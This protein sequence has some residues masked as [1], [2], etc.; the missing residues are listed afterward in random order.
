MKMMII[1][2]RISNALCRL[3]LVSSAAC[4]HIG[5]RSPW[6]YNRKTLCS[7]SDTV[8]EHRV[9][10]H[11]VQHHNKFSYALEHDVRNTDDLIWLKMRN[12]IVRCEVVKDTHE[13]FL[14]SEVVKDTHEHFKEG[15]SKGYPWAFLLSFARQSARAVMRDMALSFLWAYCVAT[16]VEHRPNRIRS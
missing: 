4:L 6:L 11:R 9:F 5:Q 3:T 15:S 2:I 13:Q 14:R 8:F 12:I 7:S 10:D 1:S 16:L